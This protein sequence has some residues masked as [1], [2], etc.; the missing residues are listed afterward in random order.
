ME[1]LTTIAAVRRW[2]ASV[3][4]SVGF[5]PT[6]GAL[7]AGHMVLVRRSMA[8]NAQTIAS[9]YVNPKQF[10]TTEDL[11][12]YP[13]SMDDD[14][15]LLEGLGV[16]AAFMPSVEEIYP[17][18]FATSVEVGG[19]LTE[20]LEAASRPEHFR[21]VTTVVTKLMQIVRSRRTYFGMK[22]AQ[23]LLILAKLV[24]D[25]AIPTV[26]TPVATVCDAD[27]LALS[28]RN[29][30]LSAEERAAALVIPRALDAAEALYASGERQGAPLREAM[31]GALA[32]ET[33]FVSDY[34]TCASIE[35]LE[36][37]ETVTGMA[38]LAI[39]GTVGG[40]HLIDNRW[41]GVDE[42]SLMV[43]LAPAAAEDED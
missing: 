28:S 39:A 35:T 14:C 20:Q 2:Q 43:A 22:D 9:I 21:G 15:A 40:T 7:H 25:L 36:D 33:Q 26:V 27:G 18:G 31:F 4:G 34:A 8:E 3:E 10:G 1:R 30:Y 11:S 37:L 29:V 32:T 23:Q 19:P 17:A 12:S 16:G 24:R 5:V 41:L 38:L 42:Q 13:R 6:M